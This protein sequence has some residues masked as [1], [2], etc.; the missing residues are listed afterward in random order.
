MQAAIN[1]ATA[2]LPADL[3]LRPYFRKVNPA[4][5]PVI[6]LALT[7]DTLA[8][9]QVYDAADSILGQRL[10]QVPGVA[11]VQVNGAEKPAVRIQLDPAALAAT[12]L[13]AQNVYTII[14]SA[15]V[16]GPLGGFQG[17]D[18]AE[19]LGMNGQ[20]SQAR[21][22]GSLV[23]KTGAGGAVR[24]K[25]VARV[26]DGV[27]NTRLAAWYGPQPAI[28]LSITKAAG[29]NVIETVDA[30]KAL[31]PLLQSWLPP[32]IHLTILADRTQTI[33]ASIK[34]LEVTMGISVAMVL[35]VVALFMRRAVPTM[36]AA[37]TVPLSVSG[38]LAVMWLLGYALDN[39]SLMALTISTGFVVDDAI[40]MIENIVRHMEAGKKPMQAAFDGSRQIGFTVVSISV[41]LVAVFIPV[42]FMAGVMGRFFHEFAVT[43]T[44]AILVSAVVSLT[45]TPMMCGHLMQ[46][47]GA[48]GGPRWW[49]AIA[50]TVER[51][52]AALQ[53]GYARSIGVVLRWRGPMMLV[54]PAVLGLTVWMWTIVPGGLLPIQDTGLIQ[55]ATLADPDISFAAMAARQRAVV[56]IIRKDPAVA[57]IGSVIGVASGWSSLNRGQLTIGLKPIG[58]RKVSSEAV[59]A[60]LRPQLQAVGG[61][62][63][64]LFSAQD[65]RSGGRSGS[66]NQFV[67]L[68]SDLPELRDW[69]Q[70]LEEKLRTIPGI[71][72]V[73]S[74]QDRAGPQA[75]VTID[76]EAAARLGVSVSAIDN[77][78]NNAF[79]QR[80]VSIIYATNN[81]YRVVEEIDPN[82]QADP[83]MLDRVYVGAANGTQVPLR[84][85]VRIERGAAPLSVHH[86]GQYPAATISFNTDMALGDAIA[87]VDGAALDLRMP[88]TLR[89]QFA[90]NARL[91]ADM[92]G[93][94]P[95][96]LIAAVLTIYIVLGVLYESLTQPLT[97]LS[98]IPSGVLGGL[99]ALWAM[100]FDKSVTAFV[101]IILLI[102]IV[103]KNAIMMVDFALEQERLHGKTPAEAIHEACIERFRPIIMTTLAALLGALPL[104]IAFGTGAELRQPMGIAVVGGLLV[105]QVLTLYTTP[106][107]YL[108]LQRHRRTERT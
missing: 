102:G 34:D 39:F 54:T 40:V 73:T 93:T 68:G 35:L 37:A 24:L 107:V 51:G 105:S 29:A 30:V 80:Q 94:L 12:G 100:G 85:V 72:D 59:I 77:A 104:A 70:R 17:T 87:A 7:S 43:I 18:R 21:D 28:L 11:Q 99:L 16:Q 27:A 69:T 31:L 88:A 33:R 20:L 46:P 92:M 19:Q 108:A 53:G 66:S 97:I 1:A 90:G 65:F 98:T 79:A 86:Q 38:T 56:D 48:P 103:K 61:I 8:P 71:S 49:R 13:S 82:L 41:S 10:A 5:T 42:L 74:D 14:R 58:E 78:M 91:V 96:L 6:T 101:G 36:A 55:G 50:A 32:D 3:P 26:I 81:Q 95:L 60:R 44:V 57:G 67:L 22:Y 83:A 9:A 25:D 89:T 52:F 63:T 4:D 106:V 23:L 75:N 76:R 62:Q 47:L 64:F 2:D 45:L 15:N 84:S